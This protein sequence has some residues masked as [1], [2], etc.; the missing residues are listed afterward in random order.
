[1]FQDLWE[2]VSNK[3]L[4]TETPNSLLFIFQP[5]HF[6]SDMKWTKLCDYLPCHHLDDSFTVQNRGDFVDKWPGFWTKELVL[7][8]HLF[9]AGKLSTRGVPGLRS[10]SRWDR[11]GLCF[12]MNQEILKLLQNDWNLK[13]MPQVLSPNGTHELFEPSSLHHS[14]ISKLQNRNF[15]RE[16]WKLVVNTWKTLSWIHNSR[17]AFCCVLYSYNFVK[18]GQTMSLWLPIMYRTIWHIYRFIKIES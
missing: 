5:C 3:I 7:G 8:L 11:L 10:W 17:V 13:I 4:I 18:C 12:L 9:T 14:D 6:F 2:I 16:H 1:M 15:S